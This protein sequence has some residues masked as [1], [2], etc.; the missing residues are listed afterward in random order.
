MTKRKV[1]NLFF[2]ST[3]LNLFF[4]ISE[5]I[6]VGKLILMY[7]YC[8]Q[9]NCYS[10]WPTRSDSSNYSFHSQSNLLDRWM[11][12]EMMWKMRKSKRDHI[13]TSHLIPTQTHSKAFLRD[14]G[15]WWSRLHGCATNDEQPGEKQCS[16]NQALMS[17]NRCTV[18]T[19]VRNVCLHTS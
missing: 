17:I 10:L 4:S 8:N 15:Q 6:N 13:K 9:I 3:S 16:F 7:G 11:C 14:H 5:I 1:K 18:C 12:L 19:I 2:K